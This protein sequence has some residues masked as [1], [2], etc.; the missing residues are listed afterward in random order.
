MEMKYTVMGSGEN[1]HIR[2]SFSTLKAARQY[3]ADLELVIDPRSSLII[4]KE[5]R[6]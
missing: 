6:K 4:K 5:P 2:K 3:I 1:S